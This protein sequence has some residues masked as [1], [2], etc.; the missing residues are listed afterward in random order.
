VHSTRRFITLALSLLGL[1]DSIYLWWAYTSPSHPLVCLVGSGC[2]VVRASSYSHL[3]GL[4]LPFYGVTLYGALAILCF[5]EVLS[6]KFLGRLI[7]FLI[8]IIS[9]GGFVASLVLS[10]IEAFD[11]HTWCAWCVLSAVVVTLIF[12]LAIDGVWRPFVPTESIFVLNAVR[13][14]FALFLIALGLGI[15]AFVHLS[16]SGE[17]APPKAASAAILD[18]RLVRP[19]SHMTGNLKAPVTVVEFGDFECPSCQL[20][21]GSVQQM[22]NQYGSRIRFV[23]RQFPMSSADPHMHPEAE[24][25]AEASECAGQQGKFWQADQLFFEKQP[26]LSVSD[27]EKYASQLGLNTTEFDQCLSRGEMAPRVHQDFEDGWAVGVRA[28]PTFF[29]GHKMIAGPPNYPMLAQLLNFQLAASGTT[30]T[31]RAPAGTA[32]GS[33]PAPSASIGSS[34]PPALGAPFSQLQGANP[35]A[36]NASDTNLPQPALIRTPQAKNLYDGNPKPVFVD[37]R[38]AQDFAAGHIAG[39]INIPVQD[40]EQKWNTLPKDRLIVFY[41][42][43]ERGGSPDDVCAF[44]R[45]AARVLLLNGFDSAKVKVYQDGLKGWKQAGLPISP[46]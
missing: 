26:N 33:A 3:W 31:Q 24:K 19:D 23:F 1:F 34:G 14:E 35:L 30:V 29:V 18:Q 44:S 10:G 22:L 5:A 8:L 6:G 27:L 36:C 25:A 13:R 15:A 11:L 45:A 9:A 7:R 40:I 17:Y 16:H 32:P 42:G 20:A 4:P 37:V 46:K 39:A 2:D 38:D 43:G 41:E 21:Q 12:I 28:T